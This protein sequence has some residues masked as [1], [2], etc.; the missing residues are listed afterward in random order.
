MHTLYSAF[1]SLDCPCFS[2]LLFTLLGISVKPH[3]WTY[4]TSSQNPQLDASVP[5]FI[6][7][8]FFFFYP[9]LS[10]LFLSDSIFRPSFSLFSLPVLIH[11]HSTVEAQSFMSCWVS[12][13]GSYRD[14]S[15]FNNSG[16]ITSTDCFGQCCSFYRTPLNLS[17]A[18]FHVLSLCYT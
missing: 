1:I 11:D 6:L 5:G 12:L 7:F 13:W 4:L 15:T 9:S 18:L 8:R 10:L 16:L 3:N 14:S 17:S 2:G